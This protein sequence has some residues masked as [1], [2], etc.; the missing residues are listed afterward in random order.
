MDAS[1]ANCLSVRLP[2]NAFSAMP[3]PEVAEMRKPETPLTAARRLVF[4]REL[5]LVAVTLSV[6]ILYS[7]L[8]PVSFWSFNN[9]SAILRNL[10]FEGILALG[11]MLLMVSG[12]FDLSVGAMAS[13]I[14][15]M[16]GALMKKAGLPVPLSILI[17]LAV[18]ALG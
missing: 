11:M 10:A 1:L 13:M 17:G 8:Y 14:G 18:A 5:A 2:R 15:V 9:F 6:V 4:T 16:T 3:T 7:L 12:V